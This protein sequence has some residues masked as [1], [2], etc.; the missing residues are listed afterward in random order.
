MP[1]DSSPTPVDP[2]VRDRAVHAMQSFLMGI[3][4][5]KVARYGHT[6]CFK[7]DDLL[8]FLKVVPFGAR[9]GRAKPSP[10]P[11]PSDH[12][13]QVVSEPTIDVTPGTSASTPADEHADTLPS[14]LTE[15]ERAVYDSCTNK[16][17]PT[18]DIVR[19]SGYSKSRVQDA[20]SRLCCCN[21]PL[22]LRNAKGVQKF[23]R[24]GK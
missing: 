6:F 17:Q 4:A 15:I 16:P 7:S 9:R 12:P 22:L 14:W 11:A 8:V 20:I 23:P 3:D 21:P 5:T 24:A 13:I 10:T 2:N 19:R 18:A 1:A